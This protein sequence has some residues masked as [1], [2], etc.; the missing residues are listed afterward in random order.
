MHLLTRSVPVLNVD[1]VYKLQEYIEA[2][3]G[4]PLLICSIFDDFFDFHD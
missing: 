4:S 1:L 3:L 2:A